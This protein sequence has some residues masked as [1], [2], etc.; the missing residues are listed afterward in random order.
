[1]LEIRMTDYVVQYNEFREEILDK[2][3]KTFKY[4]W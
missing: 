4:N 1:M 3:I 2:F